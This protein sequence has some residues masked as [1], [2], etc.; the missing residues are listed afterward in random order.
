MSG[1]RHGRAARAA[2]PAVMARNPNSKLSA[3]T[4]PV[5]LILARARDEPA[6]DGSVINA[7]YQQAPFLANCRAA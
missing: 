4:W 7:N 1:D 5:V 2:M 6:G 3:K